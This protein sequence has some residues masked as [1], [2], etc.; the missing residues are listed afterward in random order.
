MTDDEPYKSAL[1]PLLAN[2]TENPHISLK[3]MT[4]E[5]STTEVNITITLST[6]YLS[7]ANLSSKLTNPIKEFVERDLVE[8]YRFTN[9]TGILKYGGKSV[10]IEI[11]VVRE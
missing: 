3:N 10:N 11:N 7:V 5:E 9:N 1:N 4:S 2:I 6:P 8:N